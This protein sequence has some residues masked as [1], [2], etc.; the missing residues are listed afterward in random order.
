MVTTRAAKQNGK[1]GT[2]NVRLEAPHLSVRTFP[3]GL[4]WT[5][6]VGP[7]I[8]PPLDIRGSIFLILF[9]RRFLCPFAMRLSGLAGLNTRARILPD[10]WQTYDIS[11]CSRRVERPRTI[12]LLRRPAAAGRPVV[13]RRYSSVSKRASVRSLPSL[14]PNFCLF[15]F[16]FSL[17]PSLPYF[18]PSW[19]RSWRE[20]A[21]SGPFSRPKSSF[22]QPLDCCRLFVRSALAAAIRDRVG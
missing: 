5:V 13:A 20:R 18:F 19:A 7:F 14:A 9:R 12:S 4:R 16:T 1:V 6:L 22:Q 17:P 15:L 10:V 2:I 21:R 3:P 8:G 11:F